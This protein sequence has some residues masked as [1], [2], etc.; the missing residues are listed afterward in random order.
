MTI[1]TIF[2]SYRNILWFSSGRKIRW[3]DIWGIK[4]RVLGK[5]F[6][7][8]FSL[9]DAEDNTLDSEDLSFWFKWK[10]WFVWTIAQHTQLKAVEMSGAWA[11]TFNEGDIHQFQPEPTHKVH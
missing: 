10:K 6:S 8:Q 5:F 2:G 7:K 4:I 11:D 3:R 9:S 1:L